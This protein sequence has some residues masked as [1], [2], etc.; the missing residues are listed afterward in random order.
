MS[1]S[2]GMIGGAMS[3]M[4]RSCAA[5]LV[6]NLCIP[7][8]RSACIRLL[9]GTLRASIGGKACSLDQGKWT[10]FSS[11]MIW[12]WGMRIGSQEARSRKPLIR[13][14]LVEFLLPP[15]VN[16]LLGFMSG[17]VFLGRLLPACIV[18]VNDWFR[19][20]YYNYEFLTYKH[21]IFSSTILWTSK[22]VK[23]CIILNRIVALEIAPKTKYS[24]A[25]ARLTRSWTHQSNWQECTE[26]DYRADS[27]YF[28]CRQN[29][30]D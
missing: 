15:P 29:G 21:L 10:M 22:V 27:S 14:S 8:S 30:A 20:R 4:T 18:V 6:D 28:W 1:N 11:L 19:I 12:Q 13:F 17:I 23:N 5:S 3:L 24:S 7:T 9:P 2:L 25:A 26:G 16:T